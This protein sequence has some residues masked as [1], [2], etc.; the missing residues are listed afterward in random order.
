M[1]FYNATL[2]R[3]NMPNP[4]EMIPIGTRLYETCSFSKG[5]GLT[6]YLSFGSNL[7]LDQASIASQSTHTVSEF[8]RS[9]LLG[10]AV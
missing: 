6:L 1:H 3:Q 4:N 2:C 5:P 7:F 8:E 10:N 9:S